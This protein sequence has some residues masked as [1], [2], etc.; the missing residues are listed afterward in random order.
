MVIVKGEEIYQDFHL[1]LSRL[2]N[3]KI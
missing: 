2:A 3:D 1:W